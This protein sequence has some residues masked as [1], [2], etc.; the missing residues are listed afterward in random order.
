MCQPIASRRAAAA[1]LILAGLLALIA[2]GCVNPFQPRVGTAVAVAEPPPRPSTPQGL[3]QLFKWCWE[4]RA[5]AQYEELFTDDFTFGYGSADSLLN[6]NAPILRQDE[7]DIA[8]NLFVDGT[9]SQPRATRI[10][11]TYNSSLLPIPDSRPGKMFPWHQEITV[12]VNLRVETSDANYVISGYARFFVVRGDSAV[13]P[14]DLKQRGFKPD[15]G[16]WYIERWEDQTG[17]SALHEPGPVPMA[18]HPVRRTAAAP[19]SGDGARASSGSS[20]ARGTGPPAQGAPLDM[21][22]GQLLAIYR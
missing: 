5:I 2:T 22:W 20:P 7:I 12:N 21:T 9:A 17:A 16:R 19:S 10:E 3:L 11:L 14:A 13:I 8:R 6:N 18:L 1:L 4:N 15:P